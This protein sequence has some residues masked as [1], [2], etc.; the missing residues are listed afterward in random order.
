M[1]HIST[2]NRGHQLTTPRENLDN[3]VMIGYAAVMCRHVLNAKESWAIQDGGF[4]ADTFYDNII[5]LFDDNCWAQETLK[6]WDDQVVGVDPRTQER[7]KVN[8]VTDR[9]KLAAQ[10]ATRWSAASATQQSD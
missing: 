9:S 10:R 4:H 2:H 5:E 7:A 8:H 6:W 3:L 1:P